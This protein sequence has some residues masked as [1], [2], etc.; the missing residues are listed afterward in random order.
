M[1]FEDDDDWLGEN[2]LNL[3]LIIYLMLRYIYDCCK[4]SLIQSAKK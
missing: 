3:F 4:V 1:K 2:L